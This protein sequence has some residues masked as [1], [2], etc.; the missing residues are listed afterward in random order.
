MSSSTG[1]ISNFGTLLCQNVEFTDNHATIAFLGGGAIYN[2]GN[3]YLNNCTFKRNTAI[4]SGG[5]IYARKTTQDCEIIINNTK[6]TENRA[7]TSSSITLYRVTC[8]INNTHFFNNTANK[9]SIENPKSSLKLY[10]TIFT[11]EN[12]EKIIENTDNCTIDKCKFYNNN[13]NTIINNQAKMLVNNT[14]FEDNKATIIIENKE[15]INIE[16]STFTKNQIKDSIITNENSNKE[17]TTIYN[18]KFIDNIANNTAGIKNTK[19]NSIIITKNLFR[20]NTSIQD[21]GV[22]YTTNASTIVLEN[23]FINN[24]SLDLFIGNIENY[25]EVKENIYLGNNLTNTTINITHK[26]YYSTEENI[27][28]TIQ[29]KTNPIYNTTITRG[30][31]IIQHDNN[32]LIQKDVSQENNTIE[33]ENIYEGIKEF[34]LIYTGN[35]D[36]TDTNKTNNITILKPAY[37]VT[38]NIITKEY[39]INQPIIIQIELETQQLP[40]NNITL[41]NILPNDLKYLSSSENIFN[42]TTNS[43]H[44]N[45][46]NQHSTK[47]ILINTTSNIPSNLNITFNINDVKQ[48]KTITQNEYITLLKAEY[49][50][51]NITYNTDYIVYGNNITYEITLKNKG[52]SEGYNLTCNVQNNTIY[53]NEVLEI[54]EEIIIYYSTN[55]DKTGTFEKIFEI[56]DT[57]N[58]YM[59]K[60]IP[61]EV[62]SPSIQFNKVYSHPGDYVNISVTLDNIKVVRNKSVVFKIQ[63]NSIENAIICKNNTITLLNYYIPDN[64]SPKK[65]LLEIKYNDHSFEESIYQKSILIL[66]PYQVVLN[67]SE[68]KGYSG[69]YV[70]IRGQIKDENNKPVRDGIVPIK[71]NKKTLRDVKLIVQNGEVSFDFLIPADFRN[72]YYEIMI[73]YGQSCRY[74]FNYN[75]SILEILMQD[76]ELVLNYTATNKSVT[77]NLEVYAKENHQKIE[78]GSVAFKINDKTRCRIKDLTK[79]ITF[80]YEVKMLTLN[81]V[82]AVYSGTNV[83]RKNRTTIELENPIFLYRRFYKE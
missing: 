12:S 20:N 36:Y 17:L 3:L 30:K 16:N 29:L 57:Y 59:Q 80:T 14:E 19:N 58:N 39:K 35:G 2:S 65:Y 73:I 40:V 66:E 55:I 50:I 22:L 18:N 23:Q 11:E 70:N 75:Y 68:V 51:V 25:P 33:I 67:F 61:I 82:S 60:N 79:P 46:M 64:F 10:N 6:F 78:S 77:L 54:D 63:G 9:T 15:T 44:I 7:S 83:Y 69:S 28:L 48:E 81:S 4:N 74:D 31:L 47:I 42:N 45:S 53:K 49:E 26:E 71:I 72:R 8:Q 1:A 27:T 62:I 5:A 24:T 52:R 41:T 76:T 13:I 21:K 32:I 34:K 56:N 43:I 37:N 38:L